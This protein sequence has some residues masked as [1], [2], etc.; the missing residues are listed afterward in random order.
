M[1]SEI[2]QVLYERVVQLVATELNYNKKNLRPESR[3]YHDLG[4]TGL[5]GEELLKAFRDEF[6][7]DISNFVFD[8]HFGPECPPGLFDLFTWCWCLLFQRDQI[9]STMV[10]ITVLDLYEAAK[11][12]KFPDLSARASE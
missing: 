7:V 5:D 3:L 10:P 2:D 11:S 6:C 12:K 4:C 1:N 9:R 8:R